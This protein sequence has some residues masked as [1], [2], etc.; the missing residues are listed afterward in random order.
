[1]LQQADHVLPIGMQKVRQQAMSVMTDLASNP[2]NQDVVVDVVHA[3]PPF[4]GAPTDQ[5][6]GGLT[7]RVRTTLGDGKAM[8][9]KRDCFGV[10]LY[11]IG[12]VL[13]NDH[14]VGTPPLVVKLAS[15]EPQWEVSS[16]LAQLRAIIPPRTCSVKP[17]SSRGPL[18]TPSWLTRHCGRSP[19]VS[20]PLLRPNCSIWPRLALF[21]SE[22]LAYNIIPLLAH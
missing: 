17:G 5:T 18:G 1:M 14:V 3:G 11:R 9:R 13:Y 2:L 12:K 21:R 10:L 19:F 8:A 4:V 7:F 6:I 15:I 20:R 22:N 16:F